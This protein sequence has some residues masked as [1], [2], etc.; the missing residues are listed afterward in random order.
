MFEKL[1]I[2]LAGPNSVRGIRYRASKLPE[3]PYKVMLLLVADQLENKK[4]DKHV[5]KKVIEYFRTDNMDLIN[6][7]IKMLDLNSGQRSVALNILKKMK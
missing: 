6:V 7:G 5:A 1:K 3:C 2:Y 4:I